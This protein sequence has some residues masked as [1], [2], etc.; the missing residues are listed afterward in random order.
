MFVGF[1]GSRHGMTSEQEVSV[2]LLLEELQPE[3]IH[4][5]DCLGADREAHLIAQD[6][7]IPIYVHPPS[8]T[9]L[10][11]YCQ[12]AR[13]TFMHESYGKRNLSIVENSDVL[14]ATPKSW[15]E[16]KIGGTWQ[17]VR[18]ARKLKGLIFI[19][20]PNGYISKEGQELS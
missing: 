20:W 16:L 10:R 5:G 13:Y 9:S 6:L 19:V 11:A 7:K 4:H 12:G 14:I 17:T 1:T 18:F 3:G 8:N 2:R 15:M